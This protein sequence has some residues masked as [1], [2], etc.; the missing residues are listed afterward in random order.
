[1]II[2]NIKNGLGN[3]LFQYAFGKVIEWKYNTKVYF[4]L[5]RDET[6]SALHSELNVFQIEPIIEA[7][8]IDRKK[9]M[10]FSVREFRDKRNYL[11]Y[12]YFKIRRKYQ[13]NKLITEPYPSQFMN[14]FN[15]I[16]LHKEYYFLG[17]W[18]NPKYFIGYEEKIRELFQPNDKSVYQ[19]SVALE[20]INSKMETVSLHFRRG[21]Y[22]ISGFN[23][24]TSMDYYTEAINL[25]V[26]KVNNP[27]FYIFTD[28]PEW[29][30]SNFVI[31]Y[32]YKIITG[33]NC[34]NAYIDILLMSKCKSH[35]IANSSFSWWGAWIDSNPNKIVI[36]PK[37][38]YANPERD[39]FTSE[40]TPDE[41]I[42]I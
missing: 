5:L 16:D 3:Q 7:K 19:T 41:W 30:K 37:K 24:P 34:N 8:P 17:F 9:Y 38:W 2:I 12:I 27:F 1:M 23:E 11:K 36:A 40:I 6:E 26:S 25:L 32:P 4:D 33:N 28:E 39:K 10:P 21:D 29:V 22:L 35:I 31:K 15:N 20:I 14:V 18:Q 42:R 13:K